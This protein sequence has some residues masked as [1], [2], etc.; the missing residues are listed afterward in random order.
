MVTRTYNWP[1]FWVRRTASTPPAIGHQSSPAEDASAR[2]SLRVALTD[3]MSVGCL[4]LLGEPG[5]GKSTAVAE[6]VET[7]ARN[8]VPADRLILPLDLRSMSSD[9]WLY[10]NLFDSATFTR[11]RSSNLTDLHVFL[12]SFDECTTRVDNAA[13]LIVDTLKRLRGDGAP[14]DRLYLRIICRTAVWPAHISAELSTLWGSAGFSVA[15][16]LP[17][18]E[19]DVIEASRQVGIDTSGFLAEI[20]DKGVSALASRPLTLLML[21][22]EFKRHGSLP[23][24]Q[25]DLYRRGCERLCREMKRNPQRRR[26]L[27]AAQRMKIAGRIA[28]VMVFSGRHTVPTEIDPLDLTDSDVVISTLG[29]RCERTRDGQFPV[30][31]VAVNETLDTGLFAFGGE[32]RLTFSHWSFA[33]FLAAWYMKRRRVSGS[34]LVSLLVHPK[35]RGRGLVPQLYGVASWLAP[36]NENVFRAVARVNPLLLLQADIRLRTDRQRARLTRA[37]LR[38]HERSKT[39]SMSWVTDR[40]YRKLMCPELADTLRPYIVDKTKRLLPRLVAIEIA[41]ACQQR[42]LLDAVS[43]VLVDTSEKMAVRVRAAYALRDIA[44]DD[45]HAM[46]RPF[47][48]GQGGVDAEDELKGVALRAMWPKHLTAV[49]LFAHL[50]PPKRRFV[51]GSYQL[52]LDQHLVPGLRPEDL[53]TALEWVRKVAHTTDDFTIQDLVG[54]ILRRAWEEFDHPEVA[55]AFARVALERTKANDAI[56]GEKSRGPGVTMTDEQRRRLVELMVARVTAPQEVWHPML[57][58]PRLLTGD[59]VSWLLERLLA[60]E[61]EERQRTWA[62]LIDSMVG[63]IDASR[64]EEIVA[65]SERCP[66][67]AQQLSS[68]LKPVEIDSAEAKRLKKNYEEHLRWEQKVAPKPWDPPLSVTIEDCLH[69]CES[70]KPGSWFALAHNLA[71][72]PRGAHASIRPHQPDLTR[73]PGWMAADESTRNRIIHTAKLYLDAG[74]PGFSRWLDNGKIFEDAFAG[75]QALRLLLNQAPS[76]LEELSTSTWRKWAP[77]LVVCPEL[78]HADSGPRTELLARAYPHARTEIAS[79]LLRVIDRANA[80]SAH[81]GILYNLSR[82]WDKN[83]GEVLTQALERD[84]WLPTCTEQVLEALLLHREQHQVAG[85]HAYAD[86]LLVLPLPDDDVSRKKAVVAAAALYL[87]AADASWSLIWAALTADLE[88]GRAFMNR[89]AQG[90]VRLAQASLY[91]LS[92]DQLADWCIWIDAQFAPSNVLRAAR[93]PALRGVSEVSPEENVADFSDSIVRHLKERGAVDALHR[94]A[95]RSPRR[96]LAHVLP[97]ARESARRLT[98]ERPLPED[99]LKLV[100]SR[101]TVLVRTGDD[102]LSAI[103]ESI[104]RL[105]LDLQAET[106][107]SV[108]LWDAGRRPK[109]ESIISDYVKRHLERDLKKRRIIVSREVEIRG[110]TSGEGER[111]DIYVAAFPRGSREAEDERLV[112]II[113][114][115]GCWN[116]KLDVALETQLADRYLMRNTYRNGLYLVAWFECS[117][118]E[119]RDPRRRYRHKHDTTIDQTARRLADQAARYARK[120]GLRIRAKVLD[121]SLRERS[122]RKRSR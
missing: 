93:R 112:A 13:E 5:I 89:V 105:Q 55:D 62:H 47:A 101:D 18:R 116:A 94:I 88:F 11:W 86:R 110:A 17:L 113:E 20:E 96:N 54:A 102:L 39:V 82:C 10:R 67:L 69:R 90:R 118:W 8:A 70:D 41:G 59:D 44:G 95:A 36:L 45:A 50:H 76:V 60:S 4:V 91:K 83:L 7:L 114:V 33:E 32:G 115:K 108:Y 9:A 51:I 71:L 16:L 26:K 38:Y 84:V 29:G 98:W 80:G 107:A 58:R 19:E 14:L 23:G 121:V 52:F 64:I 73:S 1:R 92:Y 31:A 100:R 3:L 46:V 81:V 104:N 97:D 21:L 48:F 30:D 34:Q 53:P 106:P 74:D 49:D 85:A 63:W 57:T 40:A 66:V 99:V 109:E 111:S 119:G 87:Y 24:N 78:E 72:D 12:D 35:D 15:E 77:I 42:D 61:S 25:Y 28:A 120:R 56:L 117:Q 27:R 68:M 2:G 75:Y 43:A 79:T 37:L 122:P 22:D 65:A 103:E 6:A